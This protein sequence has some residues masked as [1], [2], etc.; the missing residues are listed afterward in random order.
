M[1]PHL[2]PKHLY[3]P[4]PKNDINF[5]QQGKENGHGRVQKVRTEVG[6]RACPQIE[7]FLSRNDGL[8]RTSIKSPGTL[9]ER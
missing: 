9:Q 3:R 8:T 6:G 2:T 4:H 1:D 7:R 5:S